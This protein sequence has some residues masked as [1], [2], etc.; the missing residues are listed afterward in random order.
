MSSPTMAARL[1]GTPSRSSAASKYAAAGLPQIVAVVPAAASS[2]AMYAPPSS[3]Q[4]WAVFQYR[5][6]CIPT[7]GAPSINRRKIS[8]NTS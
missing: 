2:P 8:F 5:F 6:R 7:S 1:A 3:S 4:P